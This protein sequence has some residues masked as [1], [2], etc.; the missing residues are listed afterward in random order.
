[1]I[2]PRMGSAEN[3]EVVRRFGEAC[4][5]AYGFSGLA[6]RQVSAEIEAAIVS[7][8]AGPDWGSLAE[9][10]GRQISDE[11][12]HAR[13]LSQEEIDAVRARYGG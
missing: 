9:R 6:K 8:R 13:G 10:A 11:D 5:D 12:L 1:M 4:A 7:G 2:Q 3:D